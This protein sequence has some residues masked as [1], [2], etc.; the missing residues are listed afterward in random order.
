MNAE[1]A[2]PDAFQPIAN[3]YIVGNPIRDPGMF[4]GREDDFAYVKRKFF[5]GKEGGIIVLCGARRSGKTSILFQILGGRLGGDFLPVLTDMQSM[6]INND[7]DFLTKVAREIVTAVGHCD[8]TLESTQPQWDD[9]PFAAFENLVLKINRHVGGKKLILMFDE[10]ELFETHIDSGVISTHILNLLA[11][12]VEHKKVFVVMTGSDNLEARNKPYWD[13]F[14]SKAL[15]QRI[16]FLSHGDT[17]RLVLKPV[18]GR[19]HYGDDIPDSIFKLTAGQP[20]Y[21]QVLCQSLVDHLNENRKNDVDSADVRR[22]VDEIIENPLPQ[23]IFS[24]NA[25]ED[26]EKLGLSVIAEMRKERP[27]P[28]SAKD[29]IGYAKRENIGYRIDVNEL[30]KCL[31]NL[32][33]H[34]VLIKNGDGD[35][36]QFKMDMWRLWVTRMHS[37]WQ[38]IDEMER[39]EEGAPGKG[40]RAVQA[41]RRGKRNVI[42]AVVTVAVVFAAVLVRVVTRG[43]GGPPGEPVAY[44]TLNIETDP[45]KANVFVDDAWIG[46]SP[47][48]EARVPVDSKVL[49]AELT[50]YKTVIEILAL[51]ENESRDLLFGLAE[52]AGDLEIV[53]DPPGAIVHIDGENTGIATPAVVSRLS[54]NVPHRVQLE[55]PGYRPGAFDAVR[56][57]EDS[58][59]TISHSFVRMGGALS[60]T[61]LPPDARVELDGEY[62]GSTPCIVDR[63]TYGRHELKIAKP[64]YAG[65]AKNIDVSKPNEK[66]E[67][68]LEE[69][70]PGTIIFNV[71]PYAALSIDGRLIRDDVTYHE[72][73]L[74][75]GT[76][77]VVLEHPQLGSHSEQVTLESGESVTIRHRFAD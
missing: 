27:G 32:F 22:V 51:E 62:V 36:Y 2:G 73:E 65:Y 66:I 3:P 77:T 58:T 6:M 52:Y 71:E 74:R 41:E 60:I 54:A 23:M 39:I 40:I 70:P 30:S 75:P 43:E 50:G 53:S 69:L 68:T 64:G 67:A 61:S 56:I 33:H 28:V 55:L 24:W 11:N 34:D 45:P 47:V 7:R 21:T 12:L 20:F 1:R 8:I 44:A 25:L 15:H 10:Y 31:E 4:F 37:I 5:G 48:S 38:V 57:H 9:N 72:I 42:L 63:V 76:Y 26:L 46:M 19:V 49:R 13:V 17:L 14:L 59:I 18:E 35:T 16:S 29:I